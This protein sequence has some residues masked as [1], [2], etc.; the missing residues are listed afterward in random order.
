MVQSGGVKRR[1]RKS[2]IKLSELRG[3]MWEARKVSDEMEGIGGFKGSMSLEMVEFCMEIPI[4][5]ED[6][7]FI[8]FQKTLIG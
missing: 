5:V 1:R 2:G 4:V 7:S 8:E 3:L 6:R